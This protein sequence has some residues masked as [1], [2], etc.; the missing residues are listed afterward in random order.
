MNENEVTTTRSEQSDNS[1][2]EATGEQNERTFTQ[3]EVNRIIKDRLER[4]RAKAKSAEIS[5]EMEQRL[6]DLDARESRLNC[7]EY[8]VENDMPSE[9]LDII[10]TSDV[11]NFKSKAEKAHALMESR[12]QKMDDDLYG[13]PMFSGESRTGDPVAQGFANTR[14]E[15]KGKFWEEQ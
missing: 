7:R 10:D 3:T 6:A 1:T 15:P 2:P 4:E 14:H 11:D 5:P 9:L 8:L 13:V 12:R